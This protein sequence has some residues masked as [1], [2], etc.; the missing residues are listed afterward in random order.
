MR[1]DDGIS[2]QVGKAVSFSQPAPV[3]SQLT[4]HP[5]LESDRDYR[6]GNFHF[7]NLS[8][9]RGQRRSVGFIR[10]LDRQAGD[11]PNRGT[12]SGQFHI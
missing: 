12:G 4:S 10:R 3:P 7:G 1:G 2:T 11:L 6:R 5:S 8:E 9:A